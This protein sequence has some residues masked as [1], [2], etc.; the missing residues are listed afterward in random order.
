MRLFVTVALSTILALSALFA[1]AEQIVVQA[2]VQQDTAKI[3][4]VELDELVVKESLVKHSAKGDAYKVTEAMRRGIDGT[5]QL[6]GRLPGVVYDNVNNSITVRNDSKVQIIVNGNQVDN[7]YLNAISPE[8]VDE[9]EVIYM[10]QARY[11]AAGYRYV[12]DIKLKPEY[13]GHDIYVGNFLMVSAGDNNGDDVVANEQPQAMYMYS[14]DKVDFNVGYAFGEINWNY[15]LS[16]TKSYPGI[17]DIFTDEYTEK[18][19]NDH[20]HNRTHAAFAGLDWHI[21]QRQTLSLRAS[22]ENIDLGR[23]VENRIHTTDA[24]GIEKL[25]DEVTVSDQ[26]SDQF[27]GAMLYR[28]NFNEKWDIYASLGYDRWNADA[29]NCYSLTGSYASRNLYRNSRDYLNG[30]FDLTYSINEKMSLNIGYMGTWNRYDTH[31]KHG[32]RLVAQ[33]I[34][35][36]HQ[37]YACYDFM[38]SGNLLLHVGI[39]FEHIGRTGLGGID[40]GYNNLLPQATLTYLPSETVRITADYNANMEYPL[41]YQLSAAGYDIDS[42]MHYEGNPLLAPARTHRLSLSVGVGD[43]FYA[44]VEYNN[45]HDFLTEWYAP[46]G[47]GKFLSTFGNARYHNFKAMAGYD[48]KISKYVV[49]SNTLQLSYDKIRLGNIADDYTNFN[50]VSELRYWLNPWRMQLMGVYSRNMV[51]EPQ[52][53]GWSDY[54]QDMWQVAAQKSFF[55]NRLAVSLIYIPPL[56]VGLRRHQRSCVETPFY[57]TVQSL[58]LKTYDNMVLLRLQF[59]FSTGKLRRDALRDNFNVTKEQGKDRGLM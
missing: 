59:R 34:D 35:S 8:R 37:A 51:R 17:A 30:N 14:G 10:P 11:T 38:P 19:P 41:Q 36:R 13:R 44:S 26:Q 9:V 27:T 1:K 32:N 33:T 46:L 2:S 5:M 55:D 43:A 48:W 58:N 7:S 45:T 40:K 47:G 39:G 28:G 3:D 29:L 25:H 42:L 20:N 56:H 50:M 54:G 12:I 57:R 22:Y 24:A 31:T 16:Y 6:L 4:S 53:Q 52:L 21:R 18:N 15:P 23:T 49:W